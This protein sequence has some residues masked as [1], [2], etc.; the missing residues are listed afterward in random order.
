MSPSSVIV[1]YID[2]IFIVSRAVTCLK[3][4]SV[5]GCL[6]WIRDKIGYILQVQFFHERKRL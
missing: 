5:M 4:T 3:N 2:V 1:A 6:S